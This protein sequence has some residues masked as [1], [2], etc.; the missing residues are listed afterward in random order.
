MQNSRE[1]I[2]NALL[3]KLQTILPNSQ[4]QTFSRVWRPHTDY[5]APQLPAVVLDEKKEVA[6]AA[7]WGAPALYHLYVDI[8]LYVLNDPLSQI[9]GQETMVPMT[10]INELIDLLEN[11]PLANPPGPPAETLGGLVVRAY[12]E[13]D[14]LKAVATGSS[15]Q[16]YSLARV[17]LV[18][19]TT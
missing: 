16:L 13:G 19:F 17:P 2:Y 9:P 3:A 12:I 11:S 7:D 18:I 4:V 1:A 6:K 10:P 14:I 8:W 15:Q 5:K